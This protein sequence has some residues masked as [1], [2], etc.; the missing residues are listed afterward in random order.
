MS[1]VGSPLSE[2]KIV[3]HWRTANASNVSFWNSLQ[4]PVFISNS[5]HKTRIYFK[6]LIGIL[7][8]VSFAAF[9]KFQN[10][11][12]CLLIMF[13]NEGNA[14]NNENVIS[15]I[16]KWVLHGKDNQQ[17]YRLFLIAEWIIAF[18]IT[19]KEDIRYCQ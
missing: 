4:W 2:Q 13:F 18:E 1:C 15:V 7:N 12:R 10:P 5:V 16:T 6:T 8:A 3:S 19:I 14:S 9:L 17:I 11:L